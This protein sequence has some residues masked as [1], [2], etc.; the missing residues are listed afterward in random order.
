MDDLFK[1]Y[2]NKTVAVTGASG[3]L[4]SVLVEKLKETSARILR[5]SRKSINPLPGTETLRV[6]VCSGRCWKEIVENSD[7]I[8]HLSGNTSVY[9]AVQNVTESLDSTVRPITHLLDSARI[10]NRYPTVVYASTATVYGLI[11]IFP[12]AENAKPVPVT[13]YDLHKLFAENQ[14]ALASEKGIVNAVSLRL[15]NVYGPSPS[16]SS[17]SDRGILNKIT[18]MALRGEKLSLFGSGDYIRDYVY[19]DDVAKAFLFAGVSDK[20]CGQSFNVASGYGITIHDAFSKVRDRVAIKTGLEAVDIE[21]VDWPKGADPI[22]TRNFVAD[23]SRISS[24][25]CLPEV[26]L[27]EGIDKMINNFRTGLN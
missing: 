22:E 5:I 21:N 24:L 16:M 8:F 11:N 20:M 13:N 26:S 19:I 17:A 4:A 12:V 18:M 23:I 27:D 25:G 7:I 1:K 14:L 9:T 2:E 15:A 3:Y 10:T 6:D